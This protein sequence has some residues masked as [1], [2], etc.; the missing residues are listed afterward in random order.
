MVEGREA[1]VWACGAA[2]AADGNTCVANTA[3]VLGAR[4]KGI[5]GRNK[6][7][8][9]MLRILKGIRRRLCEGRKGEPKRSGK[10]PRDEYKE[11]VEILDL[12]S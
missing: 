12:A 3:H 1:R 6:I 11:V 10:I 7:R 5:E 8:Q 9:D 2:G 4:C